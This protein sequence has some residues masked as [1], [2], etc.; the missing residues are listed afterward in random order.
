MSESVPTSENAQALPPGAHDAQN[1][2][3]PS[4]MSHLPNQE[5]SV[6]VSPNRTVRSVFLRKH[7]QHVEDLV[8]N[9]SHL[10]DGEGG[11]VLYVA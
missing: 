2:M 7:P 1:V 3:S 5:E 6:S 8:F 9:S 10:E 11:S 4:G